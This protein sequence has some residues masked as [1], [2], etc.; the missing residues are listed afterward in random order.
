MKYFGDK[1]NCATFA[2]V[3]VED[4]RSSAADHSSGFPSKFKR[5]QHNFKNL[6]IW[7]GEFNGYIVPT[8]DNK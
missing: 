6:P 5:F 3:E 4:A 1:K 8:K 7:E 2:S